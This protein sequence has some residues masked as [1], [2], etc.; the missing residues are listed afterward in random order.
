MAK[1]TYTEAFRAE[2]C[3]LVTAEKYSKSEVCRK[4]G[5][6]YQALGDWLSSESY[7]ASATTVLTPALPRASSTSGAKSGASDPTPSDARAP[8]I[9]EGG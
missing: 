1:K 6:S 9:L 7:P 5:V 4:L 3:K 2:A 8:S